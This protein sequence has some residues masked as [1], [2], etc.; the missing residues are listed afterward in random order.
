MVDGRRPPQPKILLWVIPLNEQSLYISLSTC[1]SRWQDFIV[2]QAKTKHAFHAETEN[3]LVLLW[4]LN[5]DHR[6]NTDTAVVYSVLSSISAL[7]FY[8]NPANTRINI[9][10]PASGNGYPATV[11]S[12]SYVK[13]C[14]F[15]VVQFSVLGL[16]T[17]VHEYSILDNW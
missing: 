14:C 8:E 2:F 1:L 13:P 12:S 15:W 11:M 9:Q 17:A 16:L 7:C 6:T 5:G 4:S 10:R 3:S